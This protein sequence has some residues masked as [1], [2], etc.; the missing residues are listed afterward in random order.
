MR[1]SACVRVCDFVGAG[2]MDP[3]K[4]GTADTADG[5]VFIWLQGIPQRFE[6]R[7]PAE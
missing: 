3:R 5:N 4:C 7:M 6:A 1:K 2:M